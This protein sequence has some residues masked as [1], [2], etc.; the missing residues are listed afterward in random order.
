MENTGFKAK[1]D[2]LIKKY[3]KPAAYALGAFLPFL[4]LW[5]IVV[6][7]LWKCV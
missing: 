3:K 1:A 2:A 4:I 5:I 7:L 6:I